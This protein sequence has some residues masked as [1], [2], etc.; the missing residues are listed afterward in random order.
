MSVKGRVGELLQA[1]GVVGHEVLR[2]WEV[3]GGVVVAVR[4]LEIAG[5]LAQVGGGSG[6][7]GHK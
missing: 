3:A 7:G 6:G 1:G 5:D 4:A 2:S